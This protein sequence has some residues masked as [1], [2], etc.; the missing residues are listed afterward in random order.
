M[1]AILSLI[2]GA[3]EGK[4]VNLAT[5]WSILCTIPPLSVTVVIAVD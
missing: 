3:I 1:S 5:L 2:Q 4:R